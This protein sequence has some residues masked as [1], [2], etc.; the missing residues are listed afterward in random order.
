[1]R[2]PGTW[3]VILLLALGLALAGG[4][5]VWQ[6]WFARQPMEYWGTAGA[7][8]I[9][10]APQVEVLELEATGPPDGAGPANGNAE[11]L[12]VGHEAHRITRR[13]EASSARGLIHVRRGLVNQGLFDFRAGP[14]PEPIEWRY[15]V[16]FVAPGAECRVIVSGDGRWVCRPDGEPLAIA[17]DPRGRSPL[18]PFLEEQ[19]GAP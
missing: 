10:N 1:M 3:I 17:P 18:L 15:G 12:L 5:L 19:L 13:V 14:P 9:V 6:W 7:A 4:N 8:L 2:S 11:V 16:R